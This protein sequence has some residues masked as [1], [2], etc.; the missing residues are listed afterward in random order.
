MYNRTGYVYDDIFLD[1]ELEPFHPESPLRLAAL[2]A[3]VSES[4]LIDKLERIP[5]LDDE[6]KVLHCLESVHTL[7]HIHEVTH[8]G[9]SGKVA[10]QAVAG[11]LAAVD[12]VCI[13]K[14]TN[15]FCA[16]RPPGHHAHNNVNND[17][18][19]KGEGFCFLNTIAIAARY[20]QQEW[21]L[22]NVLIVDWDYHHGNGTEDVFYED[23]SVFY[24]STHRLSA[25]PGTG[26]PMRRGRGAGMGYNCN[27]PLPSPD[28]PYGMVTDEHLLAAFDDYLLP[29]LREVNFVP[30]IVLISA[31][32]D[33]REKDVLG[34]FSIT[35]DG[36]YR[37]TEKV[38][39]FAAGKCNGRIV[40]ALEGGYNPEGLASAAIAHIH[41]LLGV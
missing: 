17:G 22:K 13:G 12:D 5:L 31:G 39:A 36:F 30:D 2:H 41:A 34:D 3:M 37:I 1:H 9:V 28:N 20:A 25:Y 16:V 33:S 6:K 14:I 4:G 18:V 24:F 8:C 38:V 7:K 26:H 29:Q 32:F 40:S 21:K 19:C 15:A 11:V 23:P 10:L 27:I 35:D